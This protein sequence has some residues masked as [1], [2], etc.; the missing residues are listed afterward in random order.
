MRS[1]IFVSALVFR[2]VEIYLPVVKLGSDLRLRAAYKY[3]FS[4]SDTAAQGFISSSA[5][6]RGYLNLSFIKNIKKPVK[7][8]LI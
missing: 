1:F 6:R 7:L 8:D 5:F 3:A 4:L 2:V